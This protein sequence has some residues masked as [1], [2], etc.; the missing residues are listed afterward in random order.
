MP[1]RYRNLADY[2]ARTGKTQQ[3]LAARL[4]VSRP[5]VSLLAS[6]ER[7]PSL[8]LALRISELTGVP[9]DALVVATDKVSA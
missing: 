6:G 2:F 4:G 8:D 7:Q 9:L 3:S 1:R 5:Y